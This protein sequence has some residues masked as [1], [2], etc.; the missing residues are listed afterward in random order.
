MSSP[1]R[2]PS[3]AR[4][5]S[6]Q[7][8][9]SGRIVSIQSSEFSEFGASGES[10]DSRRLGD[11]SIRL[12]EMGFVEGARVEVAHAAPFGGDPIAIRV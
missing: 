10:G 7:V 6:L 9:Q 8:G 4:L 12:R 2:A 5:G 11:F 3:T 1:V